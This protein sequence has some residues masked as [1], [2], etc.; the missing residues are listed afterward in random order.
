MRIAYFGTALLLILTA[1]VAA[2]AIAV[3]VAPSARVSSAVLV[4]EG[5]SQVLDTNRPPVG[6]DDGGPSDA[7]VAHSCAS[8]IDS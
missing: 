3:D 8:L 1:L 2:P 6:R 7:V 5:P 4:R